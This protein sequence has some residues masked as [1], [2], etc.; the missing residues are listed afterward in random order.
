[1][2]EQAFGDQILSCTQMFQWHARFKTGHTSVD[3]D[4]QTRRPTSCTTPETVA[5]IQEL[6][7]Q[8]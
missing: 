6:A 2:I 7:H 1:M 5:Q 3:D 8:D 4:E